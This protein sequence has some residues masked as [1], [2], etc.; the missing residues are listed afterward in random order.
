MSPNMDGGLMPDREVQQLLERI[1]QLD[2]STMA[3]DIVPIRDVCEILGSRWMVEI[4]TGVARGYTR[5]SELKTFLYEITEKML[6]SGLRQ[7]VDLQLLERVDRAGYSNRAQYRIT[8]QGILLFNVIFA[9]QQW[10]ETYRKEV[11][12]AGNLPTGK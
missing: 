10:G 1:Q 5:F 6:A 2:E 4:L 8:R 9:M 12:G 7:L 11:F 3:S